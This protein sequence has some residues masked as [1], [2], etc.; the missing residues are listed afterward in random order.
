MKNPNQTIQKGKL[1]IKNTLS[2][3]QV[4]EKAPNYILELILSDILNEI[5]DLRMSEMYLE[6]QKETKEEE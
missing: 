2:K 3:F 1:Q 5:K 4:E 6:T